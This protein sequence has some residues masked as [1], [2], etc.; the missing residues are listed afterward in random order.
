VVV[1]N[2]CRDRTLEIVRNK[3]HRVPELRVVDAKAKRGLSH[4][5]NVGA[6]LARGDFLAFCDADD[7]VT[8]G[9]LEAMAAAAPH[10]DLVG[11]RL[12]WDTLNEP[13]VIARRRNPPMT[14]LNRDHD[15]LR[16]ASGGNLGVWTSVAREIGWDESFVFG[17]SDQV[18]AWRAQLGG[19]RLAFAPDAVV[20]MRFRRSLAREARQFYRYGKAGARVYRT[21]R[22]RGIPRPDNRAALGMWAEL[23]R[24]IPDLWASSERRGNWVLNL[25]YRLGRLTGSVRARALV[26]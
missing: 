20:Q 19:Y 11:G 13:T 2:G 14:G 23:A 24:R 9:W 1:D 21:F 18:F 22:G 26:L 25:A 6:A 10:S 3:A 5:R 4:A 7:V 12:M 16:Y 8:A 15:W 17:A